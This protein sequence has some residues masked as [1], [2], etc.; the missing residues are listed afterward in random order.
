MVASAPSQRCAQV[1]R[2]GGVAVEAD[3]VDP[4]VAGVELPQVVVGLRGRR[5]HAVDVRAPDEGDVGRADA[6]GFPG[7]LACRR[8]A[9][10]L[11]DAPPHVAPHVRVRPEG[12]AV[13]V[14]ALL[15]VPRVP[16]VPVAVHLVAEAQ[17]HGVAERLQ[18][19]GPGP[20]VGV[21]RPGEDVLD[22]RRA[23]EAPGDHR[24]P[25]HAVVVLHA[26]QPGAGIG[27]GEPLAPSGEL[28]AD[29]HG[30]DAVP[31]GQVAGADAAL[32][33]AEVVGA[34][35]VRRARVPGAVG[36]A[37]V[38]TEVAG[39]AAHVVGREEQ[40]VGGHG[41]GAGRLKASRPCQSSQTRP[42]STIRAG[43]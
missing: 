20:D 15:H 19:G 43:T 29:V 11:P 9:E 38:E 16:P 37:G 12:G 10:Q 1:G 42:G 25:A 30:V 18:V 34:H 2:P 6:G 24:D 27:Q 40:G 39:R 8:V 35:V 41:H 17:E 5:G 7:G 13:R 22:G 36:G 3:P 26:G 32:D 14:G 21:L 33:G 28:V 31:G 23:V 4:P